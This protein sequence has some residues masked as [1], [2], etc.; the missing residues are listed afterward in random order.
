MDQT[1]CFQMWFNAFWENLDKEKLLEHL[2][3]KLIEAIKTE[4]K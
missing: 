1:K 3:N 2:L 4:F